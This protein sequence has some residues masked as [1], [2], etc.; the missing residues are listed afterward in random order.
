M[1]FDEYQGRALTTANDDGVEL[2]H[3]VLG[4]VGEAGEVAGKF[5]KWLRDDYG[6][7]TK[8]DKPS[9][10]KELGDVLW[11]VATLA[12]ELDLKLDDIAVE[13]LDKLASRAARGK[14]SGAG[15]NR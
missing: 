13:N 10:S 11:F 12:D 5:T 6:D 9:V 15:D 8:L 2:M 3:R 14:L 7:I 1:T 4:L